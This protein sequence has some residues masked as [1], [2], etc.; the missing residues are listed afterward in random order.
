VSN[1]LLLTHKVRERGLGLR[2]RLQAGSVLVAQRR[3]SCS[4]SL[5]RSVSTLLCPCFCLFTNL[6]ISPAVLKLSNF[7]V[8]KSSSS[9]YLVGPWCGRWTEC[10][11]NASADRRCLIDARW[12]VADG[13]EKKSADPSWCMQCLHGTDIC[14]VHFGTETS[15]VGTDKQVHHGPVSVR[16]TV[17]VIYVAD[18]CETFGVGLWC[19][20]CDVSDTSL[21]RL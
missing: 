10:V 13:Q 9:V 4:C 19:L 7:T 11:W 17:S 1:K 6:L 8:T 12:W 14:L 15:A 20:M 3:C 2:P 16:Q 5:W 18:R 21:S